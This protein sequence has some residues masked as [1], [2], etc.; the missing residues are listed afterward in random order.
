MLDAGSVFATL[1]GKFNPSGFAQF[2]GAMKKAAASAATA[3]KGI[4]TSASRSSASMT[5]MGKAANKGAAVGLAAVGAA[6][7]YSVKQAMNF[8]EA[9]SD[10][11]AVTKASARDFKRLSDSAKRLGADTGVGAT[12][13]AGALAELAKGGLSTKQTIG[14]L[15]GTIAMS[16]AGSMDLAEA[17][18]T[19]AQA[20]NLFNLEGEDAS[21]VADAFATAAN[22]TTA[23][24]S[25]FAQGLAQGGAAA[26]SA[27]LSFDET[28]AAL[29]I[30]A[31]NGF[32]SG[33]DAGTSLKTSLIQLANP[34]KK[35]A[36]LTK[37][38]GLEFFTQ[39]GE[40]KS[41]AGI[42]SMLRDKFDGLSR[43]Q[44]LAAAAT[45]VG[46]DGMR[47][48]LAL[49]DQG[50]TKIQN[51]ERGLKQQGTAGE[52]ARTK[53]D[54]LA[55]SW[56]RFTARMETVGIN[57]GDK[58]VPK[59]EEAAKAADKFLQEFDDDKGEGAGGAFKNIVDLA[60]DA[61][62]ISWDF[63]KE[64]AR[65]TQYLLDAIGNY[66]PEPVEITAKV[67]DEASPVLARLKDAKFAPKVQKILADDSSPREKYNALRALKIPDKVAR[68]ILQTGGV[69][70]A[71]AA[72]NRIPHTVPVTA[73]LRDEASQ[74]LFNIINKPLKKMVATII[75]DDDDVQSKV[76][77][78]MALGISGPTANFLANTVS[79]TDAE[80]S[81]RGRS[82]TV[83]VK[84][85]PIVMRPSLPGG[86]PKKASGRGTGSA[87]AALVGEGGGPEAVG[88][89]RDGFRMTTGPGLAALGADDYV[90]PTEPKYRGRA[91]GLMA[92]ALGIPGFK[93][94]KKPKRKPRPIPKSVYLG[95]SVE[96][97]DSEVS[98]LEQVAQDRDKK[99]KLT[100]KAKRARKQL[101]EMKRVQK[102]ARSY[103]ARVKKH[104][105]EA[106]IQRDNMQAADSRDDV[107][108]YKAAWTNR[109]GSLTRARVLLRGALKFAPPSSKYHQDIRSR[110]AGINALLDDMTG[111]KAG[112]PL[113]AKDV[114]ATTFT[115]GEQERLD[116]IDA[117]IALAALTAPTTDDLEA[118]RAREK[119]L[120][121]L[122][123]AV[124]ASGG[125]GRGGS[126][127]VTDI[128]GDLK[129][130][131]DTIAELTKA[132]DI[133]AD[134][135]ATAEQSYQRGLAEGKGSS[136]DRLVGAATGS[137]I[138]VNYNALTAS[139]RD[140]QKATETIVAGI[141][142]QGGR[143]RSSTRVAA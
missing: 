72:L 57:L 23:D 104:E 56:K 37:E 121:P 95:H 112:S 20:L 52:V 28:T 36:A 10:V 122:L 67:A 98:H 4:A 58:L 133:T 5:A 22:K 3:E 132:P 101:A 110:I 92:D 116:R 86:L 18:T 106:N 51:F 1:G 53:M 127:A 43:K 113:E 12:K 59:L 77:R 137:P 134:Q 124:Q 9:M 32:K 89:P 14:A 38:L 13:A 96:Y 44:R 41:L 68:L 119:F 109:K 80:Q 130:T 93:K 102:Q 141:G 140:A 73:R 62:N 8:E 111:D 75:A 143:P 100:A 114:D 107:K 6:A 66:H 29:E 55:G 103:D 2:D 70:Q 65:A 142:Y 136:I 69:N 90:I 15:S 46:T 94:G 105:D 16:Q 26:K 39:S 61:S 131:R 64:G 74:I 125:A 71:I 138:T 118:Q 7:V 31:A 84:Y 129:T 27:G 42:S 49:Y 25:F 24:V 135:T 79:V 76:H 88:N 11:Q 120:A 40:M 126:Q 82:I 97:F 123:A 81:L 78:L 87:E 47:A 108:G 34:S 45:L 30:L 35:A 50:P 85:V 83:P 21:H 99:N 115:T 19:V 54:N 139:P 91:L 17:A 117:D 128:A 63:L 48:L 60:S 33:S